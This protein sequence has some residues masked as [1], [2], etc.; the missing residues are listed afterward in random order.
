MPKYIP[1][2][3]RLHY[4]PSANPPMLDRVVFTI[5]H[6]HAGDRNL[7]STYDVV[8]HLVENRIPVTIFMECTNPKGFCDVDK[9][10]AREIY[11]LDPSLVTLGVH[12]LHIGHTQDEQSERL[13][14]LRNVIKEITGSYPK[15]L[16]YHGKNAGPENGITFRGIKYARGIK[17]WLAVK[18]DNPLNTPVMALYKMKDVFKNIRLR[19]E[20]GLSAAF[21]VH[22]NELT[23]SKPYN[24]RALDTLVKNVKEGRL[25]ALDYYTAMERDFSSHPKCSLAHFKDNRLSQNLQKDHVDGKNGINQVS[26]LQGFLNE[27]GLDAGRVDGIFGK[28]TKMAVL[29]YQVDNNLTVNDSIG[30]SVNKEVIDSINAYCN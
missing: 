16:S 17:P 25:Q 15:I 1:S 29:M 14:L 19:N 3:V 27:L 30:G 5:D 23:S 18:K 28:R 9:K 11:N 13:G 2:N 26:E 4:K 10:S 20:L 7:P 12:A 8:K 21:F 24:K 6:I 22:T